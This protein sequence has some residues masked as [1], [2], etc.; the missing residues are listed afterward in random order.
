MTADGTEED[1]DCQGHNPFM[2]RYARVW[3]RASAIQLQSS[4]SHPTK[5]W[6]GLTI[7]PLLV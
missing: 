2:V 3:S 6:P 1:Y 5:R 4:C 7:P